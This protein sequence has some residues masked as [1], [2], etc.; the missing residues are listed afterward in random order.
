MTSWRRTLALDGAIALAWIASAGMVV[1]HEGG[2]L[3]GGFGANPSASLIASLEAKEQWFAIFYHGQRVGFSTATLVPS[4]R[5][6]IPG[7]E[8]SDRGRLSFNL[9]GAPQAL[10]VNARAFI[11]S[12]WRLRVFSASLHSATTEISW[13]GQRRG[14]TLDV[15]VHTPRSTF[16][17]RL[18]DPTGSAFVNGLSSWAAFHQLRVGQSG[19]AWVLNPLAMNP[20]PVY[21]TVRHTELVNGTTA[22]VV[23]S[24][25]SGLTATS[26][27]TPGG[28]VLKETSPLG[29]ELR[30]TTR[31][32]ALH[33]VASTAPS[34]DLLSTTSI[35][36]DRAIPNPQAVSRLILLIEGLAADDVVR[37]RPWQQALPSDA[38]A[39]YHTAAPAAPWCLIELTRPSRHAATALTPEPK[40]L[41]RYRQPTSFVQSTDPRIIATA[42]DIIGSRTDAWERVAALQQWVDR[43]M[44]KQLS[45]GLPSAVDILATPV[46][47][48]H[49]HTVLFTAL[50]RS[51][52]VPTRM[53]AGVVYWNHQL[54]YHAWPE[55]W[56]DGQWLPTDPTLGQPLA[57]ATHLALGEAEDEG[58]M[59]LGPFIGKLKVRVLELVE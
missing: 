28:D 43:T 23:E 2:R 52:G 14:D 45:V 34:L 6:G 13:V 27:V 47:D 32:D 56:I 8:I 41:T 55:V 54:Y 37:D 51:L 50:S 46:G 31:D 7:V 9:L 58:L 12:D 39:R 4:E 10:D 20:E 53:M 42:R 59:A 11:D 29:W 33:S 36:I 26:W 3:W 24:E 17:K 18:R 21:F 30:R 44:V 49:E 5:D 57:D 22:L 48:C 40:G 1:L 19:T 35:P 16:V 25:V 15:T 38:L